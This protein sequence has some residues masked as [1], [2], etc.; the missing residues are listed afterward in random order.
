[1][2]SSSLR[3]S[4]VVPRVKGEKR[5]LVVKKRDTGE[6]MLPGGH[7]ERRERS[8]HAAKR[9][10]REE[11]GVKAG[12]LSPIRVGFSSLYDTEVD[13]PKTRQ[14]RM[15]LFQSRTTPNETSDYGFVDPS[16]L[17]VTDFSGRPKRSQTFRSWTVGSIREAERWRRKKQRAK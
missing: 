11:S 4:F 2:R 9:E 15:S 6:W 13:L 7:V 8:S 17:V 10:M 1:M 12:K 16:L 14:G 5:I 3:R